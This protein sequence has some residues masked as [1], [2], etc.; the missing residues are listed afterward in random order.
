MSFKIPKRVAAAV[1]VGD[2]V[3]AALFADRHDGN[4]GW[5]VRNVS[6]D[7]V[8][9]IMVTE[10]EGAPADA[11]TLIAKAVVQVDPGQTYFSEGEAEIPYAVFETGGSEDLWP[12]EN[13]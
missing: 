4:N 9:Y 7:F 5:S 13:V 2:T 8:L 12:Q 3:P 11:A 6:E 1:A 10:G